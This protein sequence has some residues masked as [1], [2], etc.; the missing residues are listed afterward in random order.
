M[1]SNRNSVPAR[2][3]CACVLWGLAAACGDDKP[4][5]TPGNVAPATGSAATGSAPADGSGATADL[6]RERVAAH[7]LRDERSRAREALRPLVD[8]G[9]PA[10]QDL[11]TAAAI[12]LA[13]NQPEAAQGFLDR[14]AKLDAKSPALAYLRGQIAREAG[15]TKAAREAFR[16]ALAGAPNDLPTKLALA[17]AE[18]ELDSPAEAERL[19]KE[20][21]AVGPGN[22]AQWYVA[23]IYRLRNLLTRAVPSREAE[24]GRLDPIVRS[25]EARGVRAPDTVTVLLG[26]LGRVKPPAPSGSRVAP[27]AAAFTFAAGPEIALPSGAT[28]ILARDVDGDLAPD[29]IARGSDGIGLLANAKGALGS[30]NLIVAGKSTTPVPFDVDNDGDLDLFAIT[31]EGATLRVRDGV[32]YAQVAPE[33]PELPPGVAAVIACDYD[34]EGDLDLVLAGSFGVRVW[35][36]DSVLDRAKDGT[37]SLKK[38]RFADASADSGLP[39]SGQYDWIVAEDF[40]GDNDVDFLVRGP[41]GIVVLDSLRDGKFAPKRGVFDL[42]KS[43]TAEP[44][45]ADFD[46]DARPDLWFAG[47]PSTLAL[48]RQEPATR[49]DVRARDGSIATADLDLDGSLDVVWLD[50]K[51]GKLRGILALGLPQERALS[52]AD[53]APSGDRLALGDFDGDCKVDLAIESAGKLRV[54]ANTSAVGNGARFAWKGLR[55]NR[56]AVGAVLEV[57][58]GAIYRRV[59]WRGEPELIGLG[60][61]TSID[62]LRITWPNGVQ[63]TRLDTAIVDGGAAMDPAEALGVLTQGDGQVGSCPF[64]YAWNG[65]TYG[66]VSDVLGITPLGL[67]MA[68]GMFVP[69]DHDEYVLV[70]GEQLAPK[71]GEY[72]FQ[73]TEELREVTYLDHAKLLVVD[74]PAGTEI[75]PNERFQFPPFP[76]PHIHTVRDPLAPKKA[77]GSDGKDWTAALAREDDVF[78]QP[79]ELHPAQFAGLAKPWFLELEFD[80]ARVRD[81]KALRLVMTGWFYWSD[82]SANMAAARSEGVAF[83]P[84]MFQVPDGK[85]GWRETGPPVGFPAGKTK[86]MIVDVAPFLVRD[87]PRIRVSTTLRLYWDRIALAVDGDD[88]PIQVRELACTGAEAYRRG[89][90]APLDSVPPGKANPANKPERFDWDVLAGVPRWNQHPGL[91]TRYGACTELVTAVDDRFVI[92]GAGDAATLR[93]AAK[94]IAPPAAGMRRDFLLYLD[95]WAKDRDPNTI[96]A[97]NVEPLPFHGMSGYPYRAD[98]HFPD[99]EATRAWR[100]EWLTRPAFQWIEP[101]SPMRE[102]EQV[103]SPP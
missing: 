97:L 58:I 53:P 8:G 22:G 67:R 64:L 45:V 86:T 68:P 91:Y 28:A 59:Y 27:L 2:L 19:Y 49:A 6:V 15:Q 35:R 11:I 61:A 17:E 12:E 74:S 99:T 90:S 60:A 26:E 102:V 76:A 29:V 21:V 100:R 101:V 87:D 66:F 84:P 54:Y 14:A 52:V 56:R 43:L 48:Q 36:N 32:A 10:F 9:K 65:A 44:V 4:A 62:V 33:W 77:T 71:D 94:D 30:S 81:A 93:F 75:H 88:A 89:F 3:V 20:I 70:K 57:R 41:D 50:E 18:D 13:D 79:M 39:A 34:H 24:A 31:P 83:V 103:L 23:A 5:A 85:G 92:L 95:G 16:A 7:L 1:R 82:A 37:V 46:G 63:S 72:A 42:P 69:P 47:A 51:D 80:P 38:A 98:E 78:P 96:E 40:D 73:L 55:D 25:L